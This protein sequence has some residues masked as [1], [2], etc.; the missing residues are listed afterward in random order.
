M[1]ENQQ[2][3]RP[4]EHP[5]TDPVDLDAIERAHAEQQAEREHGEQ[6]MRLQEE[7]ALRELVLDNIRIDLERQPNAHCKRARTRWWIRGV[8]AQLTKALKEG[9][10]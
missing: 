5:V 2:P 10:R 7:H 4:G 8:L 1:T 3:R 6:Y 9:N